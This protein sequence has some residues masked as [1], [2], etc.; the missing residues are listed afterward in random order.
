MTAVAIRPTRQALG[1]NERA[2]LIER[3][4]RVVS[5]QTGALLA[6]SVP[7]G[8]A[9]SIGVHCRPI[10]FRGQDSETSKLGV[11]VTGGSGMPILTSALQFPC[12]C[13]KRGPR[14]FP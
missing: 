10:G 7:P 2:G 13:P 9:A 8:K 12:P 5:G 3:G 1:P 4:R 14:G 6:P 11:G